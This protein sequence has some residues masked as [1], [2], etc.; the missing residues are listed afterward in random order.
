MVRV[1]KLILCFFVA[2]AFM[3][4]LQTYHKCLEA[5]SEEKPV[6]NSFVPSIM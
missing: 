1:N 4:I 5:A 3:Q 6:C 2:D